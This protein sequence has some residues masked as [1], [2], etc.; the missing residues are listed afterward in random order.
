MCESGNTLLP[1]HFFPSIMNEQRFPILTKIKE[2]LI[3]S[4]YYINVKLMDIGG[5]AIFTYNDKFCNDYLLK[6]N[7]ISFEGGDVV[8]LS[9]LLLTPGIYL[10][11]V[12]DKGLRNVQQ[13]DLAGAVE[14]W[15]GKDETDHN[16]YMDGY[17]ELS[18]DLAD[19]AATGMRFF[20]LPK[21]RDVEKLMLDSPRRWVQVGRGYPGLV[22]EV[23]DVLMNIFGGAGI[24]AARHDKVYREVYD[25]F[26]ASTNYP[27]RISFGE[28][29]YF[30]M[31]RIDGRLVVEDSDQY[32]I[33]IFE[34]DQVNSPNFFELSK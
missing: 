12:M 16:L 23:Y 24:A 28:V 1:H 34:G 4:G 33:G 30:Q 8:R 29:D 6:V 3:A 18:I 5:N 32:Y 13:F 26:Q 17:G 25:K 11:D 21:F 14:A 15:Q 19:L 10:R 7:G 9:S 22:E 31:L 27:V 2:H 20:D